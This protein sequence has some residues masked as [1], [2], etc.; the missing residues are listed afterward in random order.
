M[1]IKNRIGYIYKITAPDGKVYIGQTINL[2]HRKSVYKNNFFKKQ[3][4]LS[5]SCKKY[6]WNPIDTFEI[7]EEC[8]CVE[9]KSLLNEREIYWITFYDSFKNGLNCNIGGGSN[10]GYKHTEEAKS[11]IAKSKIGNNH[12]IGKECSEETKNKIAKAN[13]LKII[14]LTNNKIYDSLQQAAKEL[15]LSTGHI[16][17]VCKNK[18]KKTKGYEF[19]YY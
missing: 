18:A 10:F 13:S 11:K 8:L 15:N 5:R 14:C 19:K 6:N 4:K 16:A 9:D 3:Y 1:N 2:Y 12:N 17:A 7:I